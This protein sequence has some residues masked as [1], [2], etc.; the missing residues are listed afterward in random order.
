MYKFVTIFLLVL[1]A[2]QV[3]AARP[4]GRN[5]IACDTNLV[6][7][8]FDGIRKFGCLV[9]PNWGVNLTTARVCANPED[10]A[11]NLIIEAPTAECNGEVPPQICGFGPQVRA[12][13]QQLQALF[14]VPSG[15][16]LQLDDFLFP[17]MQHCAPVIPADKITPPFLVETMP[18]SWF[19][20]QVANEQY[21]FQIYYKSVIAPVNSP[22]CLQE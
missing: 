1:I 12:Y 16:G 17:M 5:V 20:V 10:C 19:A 13:S 9:P 14:P 7:I 4:A 21:G 8:S 11:A 15:W 18:G 2:T 3:Q 22:G 6:E